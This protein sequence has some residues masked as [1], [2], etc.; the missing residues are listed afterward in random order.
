MI[1]LFCV[2][3]QQRSNLN[4]CIFSQIL[5]GATIIYQKLTRKLLS[6]HSATLIE[7]FLY[8]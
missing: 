2:Y 6:I 4:R 3:L 7:Y 5:E 8:L 1:I